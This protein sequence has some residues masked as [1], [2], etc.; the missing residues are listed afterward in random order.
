MD[1]MLILLLELILTKFEIEMWGPDPPR[2]K[3]GGA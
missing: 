1:P 3:S 2:N